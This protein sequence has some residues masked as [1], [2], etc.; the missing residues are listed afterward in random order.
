MAAPAIREAWRL[1]ASPYSFHYSRD[2]AHHPV[3]VIGLERQRADG[4]VWGGTYF[5]NS[6]GQP[7]AY[8]YGGQRLDHW[9]KHPQLFAQW[10]AGVLY[11]YKG[12]FK[13][14]VPFNHGGF[15]PGLV[16]SVGW[17]FTPL[18]SAQFNV[19]G[20]SALM[21]QLSVDLP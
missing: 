15:S 6:F 10:T 9:S 2:A 8:V 21:L 19:L 20:N 13:D 11:G 7:S 1:I 12:E 17:Q 16:L 14:K 18:Y 3:R 4:T 5:S